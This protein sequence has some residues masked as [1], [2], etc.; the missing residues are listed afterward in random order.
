[1]TKR[2]PTTDLVS[3]L[4][5]E[6]RR[7]KLTQYRVSVDTGIKQPSLS[8]LINGGSLKA[9]TAGVLLEYLG[10]EL[11]RKTQRRR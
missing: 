8:R 3:L 7:Q 2:V 9:E 4:R 10:F 6:L 1:M 11:I 5:A